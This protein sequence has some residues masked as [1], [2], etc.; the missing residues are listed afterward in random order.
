MSAA[1]GR[2]IERERGLRRVRGPGLQIPVGRVPSRGGS[3]VVVYILDELELP[4]VTVEP[5]GNR[6]AATWI[7]L[8]GGYFAGRRN[9]SV[10]SAEPLSWR[11]TEASRISMHRTM[12]LLLPTLTC[13]CSFL[14]CLRSLTK[15]KRRWPLPEM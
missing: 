4:P 1:D 15:S 2:Y 12:M 5:G 10:F 8:G 3:F 13:A 14:S 11:I 7:C 6:V 9:N